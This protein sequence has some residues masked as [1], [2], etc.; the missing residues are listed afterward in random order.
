MGCMCSSQTVK[1]PVTEQPQT[2][3][4][5]NQSIKP[6]TSSSQE[7]QIKTKAISIS[8][9]TFV[10]EKKYATFIKEY[11]VFEVIGKGI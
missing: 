3:T 11:D 10:S 8:Q 6:Q 4:I 7:N 2:L 9:G 5:K 1:K